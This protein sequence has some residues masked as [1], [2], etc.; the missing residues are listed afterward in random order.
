MFED[1][2]TEQLKKEALEE[3]SPG[4]GISTMAGSYADAVTGPLAQA[5]SRLYQALPAVLSM[6]FI[7]PGSGPFIDL[8]ARDYHNLQ[9]REGTRARC[10]I[11]L[12]GTAGTVIPAGT[13][14]L[15]AAGLQF[16]LLEAVAFPLSGSAVGTLEA[17]QDG[18]AY[19][20]PPGAI[21]R[22]F[23]NLSGLERY[24]NT[25]GDG[26]TDRESDES[27]FLRVV[28]ARQR[29]AVSGNGWDYRRWALEVEGVGDVKI[30]EEWDGPGTVGL[31]LADSAFQSPSEEIVQSALA[32]ILANKPIGA[33]PTVRAAQAVR[34]T[35]RA[36]IVT[37]GTTAEEVREELE[38]RLREQFQ[39]MIQAKYRTIYYGP[40]EDRSYTLLYNR[41]LALLLSIDG[42]DT[43]T[44][45]SVNDGTAD[46]TIP[47][48][49]IPV[50]GEVYV[51]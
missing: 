33:A 5:V 36:A 39:R 51:T 20:V 24:E 31:T 50:V 19:N 27:L 37:L 23:V 7:D 8:V 12:T 29:P 1:R 26:G 16:F 4:L 22:M 34:I 30:V 13:V 42:V 40:E 6:L 21:D 45:L 48:D 46:I 11:V 43:F 47:A 49:S 28:D 35:V 9:R 2:T 14:F 25:Q 38:A 41:V 44:S 3:I 32:H 10:N 15:T 17:A 18:S